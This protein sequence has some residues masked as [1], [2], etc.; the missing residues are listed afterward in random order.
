M[1]RNRKELES[2]SN[3]LAKTIAK[4][5]EEIFE[6]KKSDEA[7][8]NSETRFRVLFSQPSVGVAQ[9][10]SNTG[11]PVRINQKYCDILEYTLEEM[12]SR[13][14]QTITH[15][16]DLSV[17]LANMELLKSGKITEYNIEKRYFCKDGSITWVD[18][19]VS[20]LW[21]IGE[22]PSFHIAVVKD[23][24]KRKMAEEKVHFLLKEKEILLKEVHHRIKNNMA[25]V[26]GLLM[27]QA[28]SMKEQKAIDALNDAQARLQ[29]M[30]VLYSKLYCS[31]NFNEV[32]L[33][34]YLE[35]LVDEVFFN[36]SDS[37]HI[38]VEKHIED[39]TIPTKISFSVGII[40]NELLTNIMK[41]AFKGGDKGQVL[42]SASKKD[43]K[44]IIVIQDDG[45][46]MPESV[47]CNGSK[48]FGLN[49]VDMMA[50]QINGT[51]HIEHN[52]GVK[53][54]LEFPL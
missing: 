36:L 7:L 37:T 24:T 27:L 34:E 48:G 17:D 26:S 25:T 13:S 33:K 51:I 35:T 41:Y 49:L 38:S 16:D 30:S 52:N 47:R 1:Q 6:H 53:F 14:F 50:K 5:N 2:T 39:I 32:S 15:P 28:A 44:V 43:D 45:I 23:I 42:V 12:Q 11:I 8:N 3:E 22:K 9:I 20:P 40:V 10:D 29:S 31:D 18:L 4:L 54:I 21:S 46:G 19:N